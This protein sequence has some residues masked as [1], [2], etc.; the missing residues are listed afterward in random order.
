MRAQIVI[1]LWGFSDG[2]AKLGAVGRK[3]HL[4]QSQQGQITA[5]PGHQVK[6]NFHQVAGFFQGHLRQVLMMVSLLLTDLHCPVQQLSNLG[7]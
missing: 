3:T 7:A 4:Y 5:L 1:S 2:E 6:S